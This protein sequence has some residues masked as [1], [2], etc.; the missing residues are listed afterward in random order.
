M[1]KLRLT[2]YVLI[3]MLS[4]N[5]TD[6]F[7][8]S[9]SLKTLYT[10]HISTVIA[11]AWGAWLGYGFYWKGC[12]GTP[13]CSQP[14]KINNFLRPYVAIATGMCSAIGIWRTIQAA[15]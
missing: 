4:N 1:K 6:G 8:V 7:Q 2:M 12:S 9:P 10:Q 5:S 14:N 11:G 13:A 15:R 3:L